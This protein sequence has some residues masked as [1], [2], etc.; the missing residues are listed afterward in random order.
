MEYKFHV[1]RCDP[2]ETGTSSHYDTFNVPAREGLTVLDGLNFILGRLDGTLAYRASCRAGICGSCGMH[3]NGKYRL[4]CETQVSLLGTADIWVNPLAHLPVIKDLVVD[5][6]SFWDKYKLV[7]PYLI[8]GDGNPEIERFQT[9][10]QV[11]KLDGLYECILCTCCHNSCSITDLDPEYL[12]PAVLMKVDRFVQDSRDHE[13]DGRLD[14]VDGDH[15]VF[16][17]HTQY[18]CQ[19]ECPKQLDPTGAIAD[20]KMKL[21]RRKIRRTLTFEKP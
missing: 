13:T 12:G 16:R 7:K 10:D 19:T 17:C 1:F 20:L 15:G 3:I 18:N 2:D 6:T 5:M 14:S 4:A 8:P 21:V 11:K 9:S